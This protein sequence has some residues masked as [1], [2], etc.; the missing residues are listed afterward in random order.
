MKRRQLLF[1]LLL[2]S[3]S[4]SLAQNVD[5]V[6]AY[7][8]ESIKPEVNFSLEYNTGSLSLEYI[9]QDPLTPPTEEFIDE[10][11]KEYERT[12]DPMTLY[13][14]GQT[15]KRLNR[16]RESKEWIEKALMETE[17]LMEKYPDSIELVETAFLIYLDNNQPKLACLAAKM[18][19]DHYQ[20]SSSLLSETM[21]YTF[22]G[23]NDEGVKLANK[24]LELYPHEAKWYLIR[25]LHEISKKMTMFG[26]GSEEFVAEENRIDRSFLNDG[27]A[28]YPDSLEIQ[29][30]SVLCNFFLFAYED[31]LPSFYNQLSGI[32]NIEGFEFELEK[33]Q[34]DKL[35]TYFQRV[36]KLS[37]KRAFKNWHSLL[38]TLGTIQML[39]SEPKKAITYFEKAIKL[40]KPKYRHGQDNVYHYY[41]NLIACHRILGDTVSAENCVI[42]R[43]TEEINMDP[44]PIYYVEMALYRVIDKDYET[45][46]DILNQTIAMD[47]SFIDAYT[48]KALLFM[49][50]DKMDEAI[51]CL[52]SGGA[53]D[54]NDVYAFKAIIL[55]NILKKEST[56]ALMQINQLEAYDPTDSFIEDARGLLETE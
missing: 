17:S 16:R 49:V 7:I 12:G 40:M 37:K 50:D 14:I 55:F 21:S 10:S 45:A 15:Y 3:S 11:K 2:I 48:N 5:S 46:M 43:A 56:T 41:T 1:S 52:Q 24:G 54:P 44:L 4:T 19:S 35:E 27:I 9:E 38:Y 51:S 33:S 8:L 13:L 25:M 42:R 28:K 26:F 34:D 29:L 30:T 47:S 23:Q 39:R 31:V 32:A 6:K 18:V 36:T 20:N 53:I 22:T